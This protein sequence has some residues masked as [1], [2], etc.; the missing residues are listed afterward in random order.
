MKSLVIWLMT[1]NAPVGPDAGQLMILGAFRTE[2]GCRIAANTT[3]PR[4]INDVAVVL[5]RTAWCTRWTVH[6]DAPGAVGEP[7][8]QKPH[9]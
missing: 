8:S 2:Q 5:D 4:A 1:F 7:S 9:K 6:D 3:A